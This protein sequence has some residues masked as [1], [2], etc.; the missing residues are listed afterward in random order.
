MELHECPHILPLN[1]F[2]KTGLHED[3]LHIKYF[4]F[5]ALQASKSNMRLTS[6]FLYYLITYKPRI[7]KNIFVL[8][9]IP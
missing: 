1:N 4:N 6:N 8:D 2:N 3:P 7:L 5:D 9:V